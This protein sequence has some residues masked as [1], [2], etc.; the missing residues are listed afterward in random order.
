M[1]KPIDIE[2]AAR[3]KIISIASSKTKKVAVDE[4]FT[5]CLDAPKNS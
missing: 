2:T 4:L 1:N 5:A 3:K